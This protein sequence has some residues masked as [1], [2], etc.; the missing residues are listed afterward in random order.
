[1]Y[2]FVKESKSENDKSV[3]STYMSLVK[4]ACSL[5]GKTNVILN[6]EKPSNKLHYIVCDTIQTS[7]QYFVRGYRNQIV[8]LQG[9]VPEE[10]YMRRHSKI[11]FSVLSFMEKYVLKHCKLLLMVSVEMLDHYEKKYKLLLRDKTIIMPCFNENE[12][13]ES[14]F[15]DEKYKTNTFLYVG[16]M[17]K[18][19]CFEQIVQVYKKIEDIDPSSMFY[20]YTFDKRTAENIIKT[21]NIK[22]YS[23]EYVRKEELSEK[24]K[25]IKYGFVLRE[26]CTVNNVATPTKFSNYIANGIIPIYSSA[27]KSFSKVA[28]ENEVGIICDLDDL[29]LGIKNISEHLRKNISAI[30]IKDKCRT[31]FKTYYNQKEY[32]KIIHQKLLQ[33]NL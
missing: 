20:V 30:D 28:L 18:W 22:N 14:A 1:M 8:W 16:G 17:A 5:V 32:V 27:L 15:I 24:I 11:R 13:V 21:N 6:G 7:F 9:V 25:G 3:T 26:N 29:E 31:I 19:Q 2:N 12:I 10:S 23:V 33:L 4:Q